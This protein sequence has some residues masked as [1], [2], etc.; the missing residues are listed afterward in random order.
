MTVNLDIRED[1]TD[2][3]SL[4]ARDL[5][6]EKSSLQRNV[7]RLQICTASGRGG[8]LLSGIVFKRAAPPTVVRALKNI[9]LFQ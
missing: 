6:N 8:P 2:I 7:S 1:T 5:V 3:A 9:I 4:V